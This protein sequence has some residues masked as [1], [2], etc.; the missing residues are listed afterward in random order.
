LEVR[1]AIIGIIIGAVIGVVLGATVI[2][3]RLA[4]A[5]GNDARENRKPGQRAAAGN[6]AVDV[7][8]PTGNSG[9]QAAPPAEPKPAMT[10]AGRPKI[11]W[12]MASA[13]AAALP[14]AGEL[15]KRVELETRRI[16][17]GQ[18]E[19]RMFDPGTLAPADEMLGAVSSGAIDAAFMAPDSW[20]SERPVLQL[21]SGFPFGPETDEFLAWINAG[22]GPLF[23]ATMTAKGVH[24]VYCGITAK[25]AMG[26]FRQPI[27][28]ADQIRGLNI[29]A[30]GLAAATLGAMGAIIQKL[31]KGDIFLGLEQGSLDAVQ[32]ATPAIDARLGLGRMAKTYY[33]PGWHRPAGFF[34]LIVNKT[35]WDALDERNK[36]AITAVCGANM[37]LRSGAAQYKAL[38]QIASEGVTVRR[39][40]PA[41]LAAIEAAW[42]TVAMR[43]AAANTRFRRVWES[44]AAFRRNYSIVKELSVT[45]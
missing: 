17:E 20:E 14:G 39:L 38:K 23:T 11:R 33:F 3:P 18:T 1:G 36:S 41:T 35:K 16:S 31:D 26:W 37:A 10:P 5:P 22:G 2:A 15:A 19:I 45:K 28:S 8:P 44:L 25:E 21:F 6:S 42:G 9:K 32:F 34:I 27:N 40:S 4:N 30:R 13:A 12:R 7:S 29:R 43:E 24:G